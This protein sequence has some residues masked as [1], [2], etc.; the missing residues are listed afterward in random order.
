[1][2]DFLKD[3]FADFALHHSHPR[4]PDLTVYDFGGGGVKVVVYI[5][6]PPPPPSP[7]IGWSAEP[8]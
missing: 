5:P 8:N 1:M 4:S 2:T 6:P 3:G 7:N